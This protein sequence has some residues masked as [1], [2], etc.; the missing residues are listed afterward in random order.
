M[1][2]SISYA[3]LNTLYFVLSHCYHQGIII[4]HICTL[5]YQQ[6]MVAGVIGSCSMTVVRLVAWDNKHFLEDVTTLSQI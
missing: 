4:A 1:S 6:S 2:W 5:F 3:D